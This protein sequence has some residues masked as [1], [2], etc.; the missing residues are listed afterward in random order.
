MLLALRSQQA[1]RA[2]PICECTHIQGRRV[3]HMDSDP[4]DQ[5]KGHMYMHRPDRYPI[6]CAI[7]M[8]TSHVSDAVPC[9]DTTCI[10][11]TRVRVCT[12]ELQTTLTPI[13]QSSCVVSL[14]SS[15][16]RHTAELWTHGTHTL[17]QALP[18]I[19]SQ[20]YP[21]MSRCI[22]LLYSSLEHTRTKH[23]HTHAHVT[24]V[25]I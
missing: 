10:Q 17:S 19:C 12:C 14:V 16:R 23:T 15:T 8:I 11:W 3:H 18:S 6:G 25:L 21:S 4:A 24:G 20:I 22:H 7:D 13:I 9:I 5:N 1:L 2:S